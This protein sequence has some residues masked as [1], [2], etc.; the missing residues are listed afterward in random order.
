[1]NLRTVKENWYASKEKMVK[2]YQEWVLCLLISQHGGTCVMMPLLI[3]T[4]IAL[5]VIHNQYVTKDKAIVTLM[6]T[7]KEN[8]NAIKETMVNQYLDWVICL[9]ISKIT[10]MCV[11]NLI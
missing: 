7:A 2:Q 5:K 11:I 3:Q 10:M 1:M 9:S 8:C 4:K 6:M